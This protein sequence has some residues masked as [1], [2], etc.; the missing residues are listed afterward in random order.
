[1]FKRDCDL[2]RKFESSASRRK[3]KAELQQKNLELGGPLL[4]FLKRN[5]N[6]SVSNKDTGKNESGEPVETKCD[7]SNK[8][9]CE[10]RAT[11]EATCLKGTT[12]VKDH[13][14]SAVAVEN[15][16]KTLKKYWNLLTVNLK[17]FPL[18]V[19]QVSGVYH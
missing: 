17:N 18:V 14:A 16:H 5:H 19:T 13:G 2:G 3:R 15:Q 10:Y 1:V 7:S 11:A 12:S 8:I 9:V 6:A 4:K